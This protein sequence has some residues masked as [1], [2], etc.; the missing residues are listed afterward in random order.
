M[1]TAEFDHN[2]QAN[3]LT[4]LTAEMAAEQIGLAAMC[5][6][7]DAKTSKPPQTTANNQPGYA[8]LE[9]FWD[10]LAKIDSNK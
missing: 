8:Y 2:P 3:A 1:A 10:T 9:A 4:A 5:G 7:S 6:V